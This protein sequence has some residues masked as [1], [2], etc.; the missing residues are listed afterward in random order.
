[1]FVASNDLRELPLELIERELESVAAQVNATHARWLAL[2]REF[3]RREGWANTGCRSTSDWVAWRCA[4]NPRSAR[5]HV[6]VARALGGVPAIEAEFAAGRLSYSKVRALTRIADER[7][8]EELLEMARHATAAQLERIVRAT[9]RVTDAQAAEQ[10]RGS[11]VRFFW[12]EDGSLRVDGKLPPDDG[13]LFLRALE[14]ARDTLHEQR[15]SEAAEAE[16][17]RGSAEPPEAVEP[18]EPPPPPTNADALALMCEAMLMRPPSGLTGGDRYQVVLHVDCEG[19]AIADG[20]GVAPETARRL[21]CDASVVAMVERDGVPL[22]VGRRTRSIPPSLRRALLARDEHCQFPGCERRRFVDA[23]HII[24][25]LLGGE[26][27]LDNLVLLCRHHHHCVHE[28]GYSVARSPDGSLI[29]RRPEGT[30]IPRV[31]AATALAPPHQAGRASGPLHTG[32]GGPMDFRACVDA[33]VEAIDSGQPRSSP[34]G[35]RDSQ[36][37]HPPRADAGDAREDGAHR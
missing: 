3:D 31:P 4:L 21:G 28:G 32:S 29:F 6:R 19:S 27:S 22:S 13:A 34:R 23:H 36:D 14:A 33:A 37:A 12:D 35:R 24:H 8:E 16:R 15:R 25:W 2:V 18:V 10:H 1:M 5:E 11:F 20:P 7:S 17:F 9:K 30:E 26:T